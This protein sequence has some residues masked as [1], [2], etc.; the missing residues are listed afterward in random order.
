MSVRRLRSLLLALAAVGLVS[1]GSAPGPAP[2]AAAEATHGR[3]FGAEAVAEVVGDRNP[4]LSPRERRRIGAAVERYSEKYGL[5]PVLVTAVLLKESD[6]RPWV[7][8]PKGAVGLMQVMPHMA[9]GLGLA[10]NLTTIETNIEAGC[11]ILAGNIRRL[12]ERDGIS[13]YFWGS[14]IRDTAY[15]QRVL[16]TREQLRERYTRS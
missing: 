3:V 9:R 5:D 16:A 15:L 11:I 1:G 13:A 7:R 14:R 12:G 2:Q 6:A 4:L 8:S 10:G